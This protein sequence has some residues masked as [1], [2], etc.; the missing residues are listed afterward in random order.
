MSRRILA[1][2]VTLAL[3]LLAPPL[4]SLADGATEAAEPLPVLTSLL[5]KLSQELTTLQERA[6]EKDRPL[7]EKGLAEALDLLARLETELEAARPAEGDRGP[8]KGELV[9]LDIVLHRLVDVLAKVLEPAAPSP[10]RERAKETL[11]DLRTWVDGYLAGVTTRMDPRE[12]QVFE[13][14]T[15]TLLAKVALALTQGTK[16]LPPEP[17]S[18]EALLHTLKG[19]VARLDEFLARTFGVRTPAPQIRKP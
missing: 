13:R 3:A 14:M 4:V 19:L 16:P 5:D 15:R 7:L 17:G 12:A 1:C 9:R 10:E 18:L 11:G 2:T 8:L 6:S